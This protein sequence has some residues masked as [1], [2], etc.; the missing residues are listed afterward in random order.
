[1][2]II[3][4]YYLYYYSFVIRVTRVYDSM[5]VRIAIF[6]TRHS[7]SDNATLNGRGREKNKYVGHNIGAGE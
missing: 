2:G 4:L 7:T 6:I 5:R 3:L 1:M